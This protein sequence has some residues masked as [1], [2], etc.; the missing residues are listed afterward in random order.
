MKIR[1]ISSQFSLLVFSKDIDQGAA[2]KLALSHQGYEVYYVDTETAFLERLQE[3]SPH[4]VILS[5]KSLSTALND[6][7]EKVN[8]TSLEIRI[9]FLSADENFQILTD[10][11]AYGVM[12]ILPEAVAHLENHVSWSVDRSCEKLYLE[13][14]NEQL[15]SK[16]KE[17]ENRA[18]VPLVVETREEPK[19]LI[20]Y[21]EFISDLRAAQS[22]EEMIST[23]LRESKETPLV[24][25]RYLPSMASFLVTDSSYANVESFK[26]LGCRLTAEENK[27]LAKQLELAIVPPS[28][29]E[30]LMKAFRMNSPR[31]RSLMSGSVL[32]GI[33]VGDASSVESTHYLNERFAI[34]SLVYSHFS[35]EKRIETAEVM[36][37]VTELYNQKYY[38]KRL[39]EELQRSRRFQQPLCVVKLGLD[40]YSEIEK[41][42]GEPARD[43]I[44]KNLATLIQK[45][46]RSHDAACRTDENE[47][48]LILPNCRK[49]EAEVRAERL[50]RMVETN[51]LINNGLKMTISLGACEYPSMCSTAQKLDEGATRSLQ[52]I[53]SKGGN[54]VC[55]FKAPS[56]H[57][58]DF[59]LAQGA[60][61]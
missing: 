40:D 29:A 18:P 21:K 32:E 53:M 35:L 42:L 14:Q 50:R 59:N 41:S 60:K 36:D 3:M 37:S 13:Y 20:S 54:K 2:I 16:M 1:E 19:S 57:K 10:Y 46:S 26:G 17:L 47:I 7:V 48:S 34:M 45:S 33:L 39:E 49:S 9:I 8:Q 6:I 51:S 58:P 61:A 5:L 24:Y 12:D 28:L 43:L 55:F 23:M 15:Y 22:K 31:I 44:F 25:L 11:A 27:D 38:S 56:G 30:L 4:I 52:F